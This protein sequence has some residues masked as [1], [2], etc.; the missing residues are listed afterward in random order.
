MVKEIRFSRSWREE[1]WAPQRADEE[2]AEKE[3]PEVNVGRERAKMVLT[4]DDLAAAEKIGSGTEDED[5]ALKVRQLYRKDRQLDKLRLARGWKPCPTCGRLRPPQAAACSHCRRQA[6]EDIRA[7]VRAVLRDIPWARCKEVCEYVPEC[8]PQLLNE[9]RAALVQLMASKVA[10]NDRT[11]MEAKTL[12]MLYRC[13]PPDK[14][15]DEAVKRALY[16]LRFSMYW[17]PGYTP[18]K[19]YEAIPLRRAAKRQYGKGHQEGHPKSSGASEE[20]G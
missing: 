14:L 8:T 19:R 1:D 7:R 10:A 2:R 11:S 13:L 4:P 18:P 9:Q 6:G 20:K 3:V 16:E 15:T 17:P 12:V 5:I